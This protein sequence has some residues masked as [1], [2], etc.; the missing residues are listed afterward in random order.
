MY[1]VPRSPKAKYCTTAKW[2]AFIAK[3]WYIFTWESMGLILLSVVSIS[4]VE[5]RL[6]GRAQ[7]QGRLRSLA[8]ASS[9]QRLQLLLY[10]YSRSDAIYANTRIRA[11]EI[12]GTGK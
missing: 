12:T 2:C 10:L 4:T 5:S 11:E 3:Y 7:Q 6:E 1:S 8:M 9:R